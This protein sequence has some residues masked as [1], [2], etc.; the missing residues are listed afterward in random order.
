MRAADADW[1]HYLRGLGYPAAREL[2]S[3]M[4]GAVYRLE[5]GLVAK[6]WFRRSAPDLLRLQ[7]FYADLLR[8]RLP[9]ATPE[10]K[11]V[12]AGPNGAIT[13]ERELPGTSL[14]SA[15]ELPEIPSAVQE[16]LLQVLMALRSVAPTQG[17]RDMPV[18]D[19]PNALWARSSTWPDALAAAIR[20]RVERFGSQLAGRV[21]G[22]EAKV[23]R[24]LDLLATLRDGRQS[25]LHGDLAPENILVDAETRP[26]AL[27]DFG[28]LSTAG[29][30]AFDAAIAASTFNM[31]GPSARRMDDQ[32]TEL[33]A[34]SLDEAPERLLL[35]KAAYAMLTSNAYDEHGGDGHFAWC[36]DLLR[37]EDIDRALGL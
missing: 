19:E 37:R 13:L 12:Q 17:M 34:R 25:V 29:D 9:F 6:V 18:L 2:S 33:F 22:F 36:A 27:L 5:E 16:C 28:F 14:R 21:P 24:T 1:L 30:P 4:E 32:L 7:R 31:Y 15:R 11:A 3:G 26:V 20:S 23:V 10:I 35:Y 8:A